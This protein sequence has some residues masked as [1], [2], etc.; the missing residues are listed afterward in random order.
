MFKFSCV[1]AVAL[2]LACHGAVLSQKKYSHGYIVTQQGDT[3]QGSVDYRQW[4]KNPDK[5]NFKTSDGAEQVHTPLSIRAFA[6][7]GDLYEGAIVDVTD[8]K[9]QENYAVPIF[10]DTV[11]LQ[12]IVQ[13]SKPLYQL[14]TQQD[15]LHLY[16]K[17]SKGFEWLI[18]DRYKTTRP[19]GHVVV[20]ENKKYLGQ[21]TLYLPGCPATSRKMER[22]SYQVNEVKQLIAGYYECNGERPAFAAEKAKF[23]VQFGV[24]GGVSISSVKFESN[25]FHY[26]TRPDFDSS[27]DPAGGL[28]INLVLPRNHGK[29]SIY[30]EFLYTSYELS[31]SYE[32]AARTTFPYQG[33]IYIREAE[34]PGAVQVPA[35]KILRLYQRRHFKRLDD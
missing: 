8:D 22:T 2:L 11:F 17:T 20:A 7:E 24:V 31:G 32:G 12:T 25:D 34:Y 1:A 4:T 18:Y 30:N 6:V 3:I 33:W 10:K 26:L 16:I 15:V 5:I 19:D 14:R 27:T 35:G 21:L 29:W 13:G 9:L 28:F 23:T